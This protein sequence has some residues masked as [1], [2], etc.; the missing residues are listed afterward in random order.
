MHLDKWYI[1]TESFW[2]GDNNTNN[3]SNNKI[4][5]W[6]VSLRRSEGVP[7]KLATL[8]GNKRL[9]RDNFDLFYL[10]F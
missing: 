2:G 6:G 10:L 5:S 8:T 7:K 3:N 4:A 1:T 9:S